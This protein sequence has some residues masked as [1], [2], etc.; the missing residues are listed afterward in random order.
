M[1]VKRLNDKKVSNWANCGT[2]ATTKLEAVITVEST[3]FNADS[4]NRKAQR[5]AMS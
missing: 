4:N 2:N 5:V 1:R 3:L